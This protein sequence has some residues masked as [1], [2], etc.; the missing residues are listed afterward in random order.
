MTH[1]KRAERMGHAGR[2]YWSR[3]PVRGIWGRVTKFFTHRA[4]RRAARRLAKQA[5]D[6][7]RLNPDDP[8]GY[9]L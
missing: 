1:G 5:E 3:R 7:A 4:E 6:A 9:D 2:E 8:C